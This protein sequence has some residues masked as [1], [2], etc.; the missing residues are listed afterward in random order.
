MQLINDK[1]GG[2]GA[3]VAAGTPGRPIRLEVCVHQADQS[4]A[5]ACATKVQET[6]PSLIVV[7]IDFFTPLMYPLWQGIP[8][9]Q[10]IPSSSQISIS[11]ASRVQR[12]WRHPVRGTS[13]VPERRSERRPSPCSC[14][15]SHRP[16]NRL[17][18]FTVRCWSRLAWN[19][20]CSSTSSEIHRTTMPISAMMS[21]L[22]GGD[23]RH[24][25]AP[26][27]QTVPSISKVWPRPATQ[28]KSVGAI[29]CRCQCRCGPVSRGCH[30]WFET[31]I[32]DNPDLSPFVQY[33]LAQRQ[34]AID[35][36]GPEAPV[37]AFMLTRFSAAVWAYQVLNRVVA[38]GGDPSDRAAI[39]AV[40]AGA[41]NAHI[42][43]SPPVDCVDV[44]PGLSF[45]LRAFD[46]LATWDGSQYVPDPESAPSIST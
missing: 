1:L 31:Y 8:A 10:T 24:L 33:E 45:D 21:Y 44:A 23:A 43:G 29:L 19:T 14:R 46:H 20:R 37:S 26:G 40:L 4:E 25:W 9:I 36:F 7:G 38:D 17:T 32:T 13:A 2:I 6:D 28:R 3:D 15:T 39:A 11:R 35:D 41:G 30:L 22:G 12:W 16:S 34:Q 42:V 18:T 5:Q 27:R